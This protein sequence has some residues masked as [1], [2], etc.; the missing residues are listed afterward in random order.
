MVEN[1]QNEIDKEEDN[2]MSP[3]KTAINNYS[4]SQKLIKNMTENNHFL[5]MI[6]CF[7]D[8]RHHWII[9]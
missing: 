8:L 2:G 3:I 1:S 5:E 4:F 9:G 6:S 7:T